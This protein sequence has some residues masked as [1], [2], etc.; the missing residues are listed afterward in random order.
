MRTKEWLIKNRTKYALTQRQLAN[1]IGVSPYTIEN[2][3][4]GKRLGSAESWEKL[5]NFFKNSENDECTSYDSSNLIEELQMDILEF[6]EDH[7]CILIYK[8]I[9]DHILFTNYDFI[10]EES[11]FNPEI[12]LESDE[13]YIITTFKYALEVFESQNKLLH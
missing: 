13:K 7:N 6:G 5:E 4:Q 10:V 1:K 3:E 11:K 9:D 8:I 2:I 12:E